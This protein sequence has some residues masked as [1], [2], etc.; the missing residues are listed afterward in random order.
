M[1]LVAIHG[2]P[3]DHRLWGPMTAQLARTS[4]SLRVFGPDLRGRGRS[5]RPAADIHPMSLLAD[6]VAADLDALLPPG[7]RFVL[8]GLSMGGYVAFE[9]LRRHGARYRDR[10]AGLALLDTRASADDEAGRAGRIAAA[11]AIREHGMKAPLG[12]MLPKLIARAAFGTAVEETVKAM[13]LETPPD[14]ARADLLGIREREDAF[15][16]LGTFAGPVLI[17]VGDDDQLTP[18]SF[19]EEMAEGASSA[20]FVRLLTIPGAGHLSPLERP[21]EVAEGLVDLVTRIG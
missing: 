9:F 10:L 4:P 14:T 15:T 11:E 16:T 5:T 2:Y 17:A 12:S 8:A 6:D 13:I 18:A 21:A 20:S 1:Y 3:L 19:A 7:E